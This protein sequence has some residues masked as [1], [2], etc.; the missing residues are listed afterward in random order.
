MQAVHAEG[1]VATVFETCL[2]IKVEIYMYCFFLPNKKNQQ[3]TEHDSE[4]G[5]SRAQGVIFNFYA[6][7]HDARLG[8]PSRGEAFQ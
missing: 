1:G 3:L 8:L 5:L 4:R 2:Q 7:Q 6:V